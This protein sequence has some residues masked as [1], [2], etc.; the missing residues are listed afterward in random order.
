MKLTPAQLQE[1]LNEISQESFEKHQELALLAERGAEARFELM[2]TSKNGKEVEMKYDA[3]ESGKREIYLKIY[4]KGLSHKRT[5]IIQELKANS[6][7]HW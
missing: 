7:G 4:L 3:S 6:G 1:Q 5:A 2:K